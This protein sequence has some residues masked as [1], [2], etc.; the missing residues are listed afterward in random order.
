MKK[1]ILILLCAFV[2]FAFTNKEYEPISTNEN[3]EMITTETYTT[4]NFEQSGEKISL[5]ILNNSICDYGT[6]TGTLSVDCDGDDIPDYVFTGTLC[7]EHVDA[8]I[9]QFNDSCG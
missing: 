6:V 9:Q 4:Y 1:I 7:F 2:S 3:F 8:L 5:T